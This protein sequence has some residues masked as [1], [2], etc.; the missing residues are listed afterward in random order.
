MYSINQMPSPWLGM[1]PEQQ[2]QQ[3]LL[4]QNSAVPAVDPTLVQRFQQNNP[5]GVNTAPVKKAAPLPEAAEDASV[6]PDLN[7]GGVDSLA[8]A[9]KSKKGR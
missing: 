6:V 4:A 9:F 5:F 1:T 3:V 7:K 8:R 2:Q